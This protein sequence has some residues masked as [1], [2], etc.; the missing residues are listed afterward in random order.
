M[1][2]FTYY[3]NLAQIA[4]LNALCRVN[5]NV[6]KYSVYIYF[7]IKTDGKVSS[8]IAVIYHSRSVYRRLG[9]TYVTPWIVTSP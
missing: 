5:K 1:F 3:I 2:V 7:M 4:H 8:H 6:N 9:E